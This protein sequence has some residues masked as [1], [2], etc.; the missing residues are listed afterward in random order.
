MKKFLVL[1]CLVFVF[2]S[3]QKKE[4]AVSPAGGA[5]TASGQSKFE[6]MNSAKLKEV[7]A[8]NKGNVVLLNFFATW[9]PP[10]RQEVPELIQLKSTY[11]G[12]NVVFIGLNV[13]ET[14]EETLKPFADK[15]GFNYPVYLADPELSREYQVDAI[16]NSF[17][18]SKDGKLI[19]NLKGY[20]DPG[21]L[22][23]MIDALL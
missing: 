15:V 20:I 21:S 7:L 18:Y 12:K 3:C 16:P 23:G 13:D 17:L 9:C 1:L 10:C 19:Q 11:A 4:E 22:K 2:V 5:G 14:G 8:A 6:K